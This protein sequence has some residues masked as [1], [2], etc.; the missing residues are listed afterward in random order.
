MV[1]LERPGLWRP[2]HP[3]LNPFC[4][5]CPRWLAMLM[6]N[7]A[8]KFSY[9]YSSG[10]SWDVNST[11][12][13]VETKKLIVDENG[14][15]L[16]IVVTL[17]KIWKVTILDY[18]VRKSSPWKWTVKTMVKNWKTFQARYWWS[19]NSF[20][21]HF[22]GPSFVSDPGLSAENVVESRAAGKPG[23][24]GALSLVPPWIYLQL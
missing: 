12:S 4:A 14:F 1:H 11:L 3:L 18:S 15:N 5:E 13:W 16:S 8:V 23:P 17:L 24:E 2:P 10:L 22:V 6:G 7:M 19:K 9:R 20:F 21:T